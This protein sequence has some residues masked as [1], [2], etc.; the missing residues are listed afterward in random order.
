MQDLIKSRSPPSAAIS[1]GLDLS[2]TEVP[3]AT[4]DALI[5][6]CGSFYRCLYELFLT[7]TQAY[8][9]TYITSR[10]FPEEYR[11]YSRQDRN[12]TSPFPPLRLVKRIQ[13][14]EPE[15]DC[16][17]TA[18]GLPP[19]RLIVSLKQNLSISKEYSAITL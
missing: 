10:L 16:D 8:I 12:N 11:R 17:K 3:P 5:K 1:S 7:Y 13:R 15:T 14:S 6:D 18:L 19:H 2:S 4:F 9:T